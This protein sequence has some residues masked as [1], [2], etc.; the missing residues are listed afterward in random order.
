MDGTG[1]EPPWRDMVPLTPSLEFCYGKDFPAKILPGRRGIGVT[2][3]G[4]GMHASVSEY[5]HLRF[6]AR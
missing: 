5:W 6:P 4:S 3:E 1:L 2:R